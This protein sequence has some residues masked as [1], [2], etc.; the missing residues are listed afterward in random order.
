M[1]VNSGVRKD[2]FTDYHRSSAAEQEENR[3]LFKERILEIREKI[4]RGE[5]DE[6]YQIGSRSYT[7]DEWDRFLE[8]FDSIQ[9]V[10]KELMR[11]RL[12]K[13][14]EEALK[15]EREDKIQEKEELEE[16]LLL[17]AIEKLLEDKDS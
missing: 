2:Y 7:V 1:Q 11:E 16:E 10:L 13:K 6:T 14:E 8:N 9:E 17:E 5:A 12:E 4:Q 3:K 15:K